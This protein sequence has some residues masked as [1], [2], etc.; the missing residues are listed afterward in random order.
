MV[1][2]NIEEAVLMCDRIIV[3]SSNPGRIAA[4]IEVNA[5]AS[6]QPARSRIPPAGRSRST[7]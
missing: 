6:A 3:L 1:T 2:H 7:R 4:E 5:A